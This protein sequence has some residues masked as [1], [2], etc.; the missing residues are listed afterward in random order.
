MIQTVVLYN[1][2]GVNTGWITGTYLHEYIAVGKI[3]I[4]ANSVPNLLIYVTYDKT[5]GLISQSLI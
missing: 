2:S 4:D 5:K 3:G 1:D